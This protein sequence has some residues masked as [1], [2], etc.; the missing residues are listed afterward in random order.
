MKLTRVFFVNLI[1]YDSFVCISGKGQ[2]KGQTKGQSGIIPPHST[3]NIQIPAI[4]STSDFKGDDS[5]KIPSTTQE[6]GQPSTKLSTTTG[7][8]STQIPTATTENGTIPTTLTTVGQDNMSLLLPTT[9]NDSTIT[10]YTT[11]S[12]AAIT[13]AQTTVTV[14][15]NSTT[16]KRITTSKTV[17]KPIYIVPC[18][19]SSG[20]FANM[21]SAQIV[22]ELVA[23]TT[24]DARSTNS[25]KRRYYSAADNRPSSL[26]IGC[27]FILMLVLIF[28]V[29]IVPD[30]IRLIKHLFGKV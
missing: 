26:Y 2:T 21:T 29:I 6:Q 5:T 17:A 12:Q 10:K 7:Q 11:Y 18:Q 13:T 1:F 8:D 30:S 14:K 16:S 15:S 19:C 3:D 23:N 4:S 22:K 28:G 27:V 25:R 20:A 9:E 24:I